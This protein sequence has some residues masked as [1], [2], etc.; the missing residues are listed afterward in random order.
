MDNSTLA[1]LICMSV[2]L[3]AALVYA[4]VMNALYIKQRNKTD[5][6]NEKAVGL[7]AQLA[8]SRAE[9]NSVKAQ[10][11]AAQKQ[12]EV[13]KKTPQEVIHDATAGH[14]DPAGSGSGTHPV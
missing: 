14:P 3:L 12:I 2:L 1:I 6:A 9:T 7:E 8:S 5:A 4:I 11:D 13:L 10:L